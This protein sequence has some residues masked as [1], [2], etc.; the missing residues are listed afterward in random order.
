M[1]LAY[2]MLET[3]NASNNPKSEDRHDP[4]EERVRKL[5]RIWGVLLL[6]ALSAAPV[7]AQS[8]RLYYHDDEGRLDRSQVE[9]AARPLL[10]RGAYVAVYAVDTGKGTEFLNRLQDDGLR[11]GDRV[12]PNLVAIFV[13]FTDRYS[14]IRYGD[15]WVGALNSRA[16]QIQQN[17]LNSNLAAGNSTK[18]F[19]DTLTQLNS[20]IGAPSTPGG[21]VGNGSAGTPFDV[22]LIPWCL[23]ILALAGIV[24]IGWR[25]LS[26]RRAAGQ[27]VDTA[28]T[29]M[30][31]ARL[32]AGAAIADTAQLLKNVK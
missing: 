8:G 10:D 14:E 12:N 16:G 29:A 5:I 6:L 24:P 15:N 23:G 22:G 25:M 7:L 28:R 4:K 1:L 31:D 20:A 3:L 17:T 2:V 13:S 21:S 18:A 32:K 26:Q 9:A 11:N 30:Q 27:V 19:A